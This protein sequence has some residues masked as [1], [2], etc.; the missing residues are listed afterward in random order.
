LSASGAAPIEEVIA[1]EHSQDKAG[2]A[3]EWKSQMPAA[4][5]VKSRLLQK[6]RKTGAPVFVFKEKRQA[7]PACLF[8]AT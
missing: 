6:A 1:E 8:L 3:G 4:K 2:I 7:P 5:R